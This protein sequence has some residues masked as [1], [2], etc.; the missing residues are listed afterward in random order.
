MKLTADTSHVQLV[1]FT[2]GKQFTLRVLYPEFDVTDSQLCVRLDDGSAAKIE[3]EE[4]SS[5]ES[6]L[7]KKGILGG[8][9]VSAESMAMIFMVTENLIHRLERLGKNPHG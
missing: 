5:S 1:I 3:T 9:A 6:M 8:F 2:D 7:D 4:I